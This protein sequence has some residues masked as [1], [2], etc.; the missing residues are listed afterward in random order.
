MS[1]SE[2]IRTF[3]ALETHESVKKSI[4]EIQDQLRNIPGARVS[5]GRTEGIHL[6]LKFLG[7]VDAIL[8]PEITEDLSRTDI[9]VC[10]INLCT[11]GCG[12]FPN[13]R[14]PRVLWIGVDG[15]ESLLEL[16]KSIDT[17]LSEFGFPPE[18]RRFHPHLTVG[19]IR[20]ID[21]D[22]PLTDRFR[23]IE[24]PPV[25]WQ[26]SEVKVMSSTLKPGG[27]EYRIL[28]SLDFCK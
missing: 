2:Q 23:E 26:V 4:L 17:R 11:T 9:P 3:I 16:Q 1:G 5:W 12:A 7:D 13:F 22:S 24:L 14:K 18:R 19:R 25:E 15:G 8:I 28:A 10:H 6:T 20:T 21:R 27:A